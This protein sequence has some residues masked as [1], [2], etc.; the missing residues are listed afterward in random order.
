MAKEHAATDD[1]WFT[2]QGILEQVNG[3]F[4]GF[5]DGCGKTPADKIEPSYLKG[6]SQTK[7]SMVNVRSS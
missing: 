3:V 6:S 7:K 5:T 2:I 4:Q 1:Y